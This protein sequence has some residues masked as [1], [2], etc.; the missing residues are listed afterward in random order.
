MTD[1]DKQKIIK[2]LWYCAEPHGR[3]CNECPYGDRPYEFGQIPCRDE[4]MHDARALMIE[5]WGEPKLVKDQQLFSDC[6]SASCPNCGRRLYDKNRDTRYCYYCGQMVR[7]EQEPVEPEVSTDGNAKQYKCG[8]CGKQLV[9]TRR[10]R[11][12]YCSKCGSEVLWND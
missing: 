3:M 2:A 11:D 4:M 5:Q 12:N 10:C 6:I 9:N 8:R 1:I 7:W